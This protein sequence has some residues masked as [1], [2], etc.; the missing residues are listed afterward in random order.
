MM[1]VYDILRNGLKGEGSDKMWCTTKIL[2]DSIDE[3]VPEREKEKIVRQVYYSVNGGHFDKAF[4][5]DAISR[6]Y[7]VD[8]NG[9]KHQAPYWTES[10]VR[11]LYDG[12]RSKIPAYNFHDFEVTLNMVKSDNCN[13]LRR[14]FPQITD[15]DMVNKLVDEAINYLDDEDNPYGTEKIWKYING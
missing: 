1:N 6:F 11:A 14:W 8:L 10:E 15:K 12:V 3:F 13:K 7:Y 5:E 4:A 9:V 2:S